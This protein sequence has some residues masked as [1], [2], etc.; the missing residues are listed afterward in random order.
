VV[1]PI[2]PSKVQRA[3]QPVVEIASELAKSLGVALNMSSIEKT[4]PTPQMKDIGDFPARVAALETAFTCGNDLAGKQVL[5][6]DDL[7]QSGATMNVVARVL[8][9]QG[10][11]KSVYALALTRTRN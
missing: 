10:L 3:F 9:Q 8:R 1:V 11:V 5:L 4:K 6:L 2:P 7:F